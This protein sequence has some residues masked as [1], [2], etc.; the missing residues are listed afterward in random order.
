MDEK[1]AT[2]V[3]AV[4][5]GALWSHIPSES[6]WSAPHG[7][8]GVYCIRLYTLEQVTRLLGIKACSRAFPRGSTSL[9]CPRGTALGMN[10][11]N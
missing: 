4:F 5:E 3:L 9:L 8:T 10:F 2:C 7:S 1:S 6:R 11:R